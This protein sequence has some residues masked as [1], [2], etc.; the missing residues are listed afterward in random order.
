MGKKERIYN[1][2]DAPEKITL[3]SEQCLDKKQADYELKSF[4]LQERELEN[5]KYTAYW[6]VGRDYFARDLNG[7]GDEVNTINQEDF[8]RAAKSASQLT[9][10]RVP[11]L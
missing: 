11:N 2:I 4:V 6:K 10:I 1:L 8:D 5:A 9:Y 7:N 3:K